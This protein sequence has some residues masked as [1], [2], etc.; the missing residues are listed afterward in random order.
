MLS[1]DHDDNE[2]STTIRSGVFSVN[3]HG[4]SARQAVR[5][6]EFWYKQTDTVK[7]FKGQ[8][9]FNNEVF[10]D[11]NEEHQQLVATG[12][13]ELRE[14]TR[15]QMYCAMYTRDTVLYRQRSPYKHNRFPF[16]RR[17]AYIKDKTGTP[18]C[19]IR[20]IRDPQSDL[21]RRRNRALYL[22][23]VTRVIMEK[24]AV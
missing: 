24:D 18:Y 21:N 23:S 7:L 13:Y 8:G 1:Y 17:V 5:V 22:M 20:Q 3:S 12:T 4:S 19:I 2:R 14:T 10:D 9:P 6:W 15:E 16:V 11:K